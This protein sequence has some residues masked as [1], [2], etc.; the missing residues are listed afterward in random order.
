MTDTPTERDSESGWAKLRRR[1]VVQWGLAYV[2]TAWTLLQALE[3]AVE[4][5]HW[6]SRFGS[7]RLLRS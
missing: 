4:T 3:Y 5:F 1:K 2:A 6:P 7:W